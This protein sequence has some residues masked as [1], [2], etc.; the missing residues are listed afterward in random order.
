MARVNI[1]P[2][3][4][5]R[6]LPLGFPLSFP[7]HPPWHLPRLL[8]HTAY[9]FLLL[10][11]LPGIILI[12]AVIALPVSNAPDRMLPGGSA[13]HGPA[14]EATSRG[15][16]DQVP[17]TFTRTAISTTSGTEETTFV[18]TATIVSEREPADPVEVVIEGR[19][20]AMREVD[21]ADVTHSDGK[22]YQYIG[23]LDPGPK[24]YFFRCG[25]E[26]TG[27]A[28]FNVRESHMFEQYH[29]DLLL[30]MGVFIPPMVYSL[31][32]LHRMKGYAIA[33][34]GT[35]HHRAA[36]S[37]YNAP[38]CPAGTGAGSPKIS[39]GHAVWGPRDGP[40]TMEGV[41]SREPGGYAHTTDTGS[42]ESP[43]E[44]GGYAHTT[45]TGAGESPREPVPGGQTP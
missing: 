3:V 7:R 32:L 31:V 10:T 11:L 29:P 5:V 45:D 41:G 35:L 25:N 1:G 30:A 22:E 6:L 28:T 12:L 23:S 9:R 14:G 38:R 39:E 43:R 8:I 2:P 20:F 15:T 42:G 34:S 16:G 24:F 26:S 19:P 44:P 40:D 18:F 37:R 13:D 36:H 4:P 21:P 33:I 27:I 17:V